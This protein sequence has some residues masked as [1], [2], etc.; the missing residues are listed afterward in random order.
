[1]PSHILLPNLLDSTQPSYSQKVMYRG[2]SNQCFWCLGFGHL[3]KHCP[4]FT[5]ASQIVEPSTTIIPYNAASEAW[6][7]V[8][9]RKTSL[10]S[11]PS[12]TQQVKPNYLQ[13]FP[14]LKNNY[15]ILQQEDEVPQGTLAPGSLVLSKTCTCSPMITMLSKSSSRSMKGH[16]SLKIIQEPQLSFPVKIVSS[17]KL[18]EKAVTQHQEDMEIE[19]AQQGKLELQGQQKMGV[20]TI[21]RIKEVAPIANNDSN[22]GTTLLLTEEE[23]NGFK[24]GSLQDTT[25]GQML[26]KVVKEHRIHKYAGKDLLTKRQVRA[27]EGAKKSRQDAL[28][29]KRT[30][31][32]H[33]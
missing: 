16:P 22:R 18:K 17:E 33:M 20:V 23:A 31:S 5:N 4:K 12:K 7:I 10:N 6:T 2:L 24:F 11:L 25:A 3:A 29:E 30:S 15:T 9:N 8:G 21:E 32:N 13:E 1:M 14:P 19:I 27:Q 26:D 28:L